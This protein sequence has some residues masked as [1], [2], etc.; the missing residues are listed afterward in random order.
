MKT[1]AER[2]DLHRE[3]KSKKLAVAA[4]TLARQKLDDGPTAP[5]QAAV[6]A[7][8]A[9]I[10]TQQGICDT[11]KADLDAWDAAHP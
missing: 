2:Y 8:D 11:A 4:A 5:S 3:F 6:D 1:S 10:A 9:E 7:A